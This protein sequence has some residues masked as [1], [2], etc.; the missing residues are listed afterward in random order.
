MKSGELGIAGILRVALTAG[1]L[2]AVDL[3]ARLLRRPGKSSPATLFG[4]PDSRLATDALTEARETLSPATFAHS[5][6]CWQWAMAF[7]AVDG[8]SPDPEAL[9]VACALHDVALGAPAD[10][11]AGCF[12]VLGARQARN[13]VADRDTEARAETV[14]T[15]IARHMDPATPKRHGPE[16]ALLHDAAHFDVAG[17]RYGTLPEAFERLVVGEYSRAGFNREF[18]TMMRHER[19]VRPRSTASVLWTGGMAGVIALNPLDRLRV[20]ENPGART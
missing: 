11:H 13:F 4:L 1:A 20:P 15:A 2:T 12:A 8:L 16:A 17:T 14:A 5:L 3:P 18:A 19:R 6:R 9:F 7:G 10:P